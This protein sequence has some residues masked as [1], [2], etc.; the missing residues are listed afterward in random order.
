VRGI[1]RSAGDS[2]STAR[3]WAVRAGF[4][5]LVIGRLL[6]SFVFAGMC[7]RASERALAA[8]GRSVV[9]VKL[10]TDI[11]YWPTVVSTLGRCRSL[12]RVSRP[13]WR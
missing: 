7:A 2:G 10:R 3:G 11:D 6:L 4:Q 1:S 12:V 13:G 8:T 5:V 9:D